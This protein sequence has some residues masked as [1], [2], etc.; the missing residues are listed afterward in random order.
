MNNEGL[1]AKASTTIDGPIAKIWD[2]L[3]TPEII[4]QFMFG[5]ETVSEWKEGS[6]IVWKGT[7]EGKSYE[8]KGVILKIEPQRMLQYSHYSPLSGDP[9]V[10]ENYHTLTYELSEDGDK[11]LVVLSQDNNATEEEIE[12]SQGMWEKML[13][14]LKKV[15]E[16]EGNS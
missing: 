14:S 1:I 3:T 11:T 9:D 5:T 6:P 10:P 12:H 8:D 2:A 15:V 13:A 16:D 7:W 4:K